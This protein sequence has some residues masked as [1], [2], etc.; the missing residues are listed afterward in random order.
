M[1]LKTEISLISDDSD[2][3]CTAPCVNAETT[4]ANQFLSDSAKSINWL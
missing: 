2:S 3:A 1:L 4:Y